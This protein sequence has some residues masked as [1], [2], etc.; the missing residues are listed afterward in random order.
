MIAIWDTVTRPLLEALAPRVVV[1]V[2]MFQGATTEKLLE[3]ADER[4]CVVHGVDP[5]DPP[6]FDLEGFRDRY[7]AR[8]V[9]YNE[10]SLDVLAKIRDADAV[11]LDGDHNWYTVYNELSLL[12]RVAAE[13]GRPFPLTLAHDIDWPWGRRDRYHRPD[14]IPDEFRH[15][16]TVGGMSPER[17]EL[18]EYGFAW[19]ALK[20]G[21]IDTP[22]NGVRT[23]IEDFLAETDVHLE[24]ATV[25]GFHGVGILVDEVRLEDH[26]LRDA[27]ATFDSPEFLKRHCEQL[28]YSRMHSLAQLAEVRQRGAGRR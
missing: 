16:P 15:L 19:R 27:L 21:E 18:S 4:D 3:F 9:F 10:A 26:G 24:F 23:A 25:A 7:G 22:K 28:E 11:L 6:G 5:A 17:P 2:G 8:F 20:A 14:R 13:E 1:E 12:A